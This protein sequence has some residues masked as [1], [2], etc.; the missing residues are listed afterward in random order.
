MLA[1]YGT[2]FTHVMS[3]VILTSFYQSTG[4]SFSFMAASGTGTLAADTLRH[5]PPGPISG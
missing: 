4:Q 1:A 2:A 5:R 3:M